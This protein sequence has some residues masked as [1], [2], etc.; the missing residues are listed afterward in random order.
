MDDLRRVTFGRH[1][2]WNLARPGRLSGDDRADV[3]GHFGF[4]ILVRHLRMGILLEV[5]PGKN[6]ERVETAAKRSHQTPLAV[7]GAVGHDR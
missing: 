7:Q 6:T 2:V 3:I 1:S 5:K 4:R